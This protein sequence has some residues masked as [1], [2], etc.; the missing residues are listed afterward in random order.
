MRTQSLFILLSHASYLSSRWN[1]SR[2][3]PSIL[4][5]QPSSDSSATSFCSVK[6]TTV[7]GCKRDRSRAIVLLETSSL[8]RLT[9]RRWQDMSLSFGSWWSTQSLPVCTCLL[10]LLKERNERKNIFIFINIQ[11]LLLSGYQIKDY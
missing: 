3:F 8:V 6:I 7:K 2:S 11:K 10:S 4:I 5:F 1:D 9:H